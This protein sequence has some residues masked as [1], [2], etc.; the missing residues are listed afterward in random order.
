MKDW[1]G[2][3]TTFLARYAT[4]TPILCVASIELDLIR[5]VS[6][7]SLSANYDLF[8]YILKFTFLKLQA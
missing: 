1:T 4:T 3:Q 5:V 7:G 6:Y 2:F 8:S